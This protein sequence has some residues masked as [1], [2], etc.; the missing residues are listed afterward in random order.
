MSTTDDHLD[1]DARRLQELGYTQEL[2][3]GMSGFS[4]F[5]V[6]FSIISI[7]AGCITTYYLAMDAGGPIVISIGWPLVGLFVL[8]V[9]LAMAE[10]CSSY[11]TAGGLYYWAGQL[12]RRN[13]RVWAWYVG[14]F[15]FLG[16]VAV[17]A[18]IDYGAA[19]TWMALLNLTFGVDVTLT[20]TFIAFLVIITLHGLLNTF[21][22]NLVKL[23]S[24][25]SAWWHL[26]G[27]AVIVGILWLVPDQHQ[28]LAWT[29]TEFRNS[30]GWESTIYVFMIGL[31]MA[32]YTF[33]GYDASAHVAEETK[34]ASTEAP[35]GIVRSVWVSL[36]AGWVLL[37]SVTAAIQDYDAQ[38][39]SETGLP[40]AQI[41]IDAAGDDLGKL[42][43]LIAA[44]AQFFCGM[45]SVTA[46]SRMTYAFSRD[47][48]LPGSRIWKKV[49]PR[50]G[51][52]TNSI[53]FCVFWSV[54]L[55][56][57]AI[58]NLTAY[59][60]VTSVAVIGLYIAYVIPV[61]LRR[62]K[63]DYEVGPW[64]LGG[65]SPVIGW[66]AVAWV[67][68]IVVLFMLP[69]YAPG[70]FGDATFNY[71]PVAVLT[72]VVFSTVMWFV[73]GRKNFMH[74]AKDEYTTKDL[75]DI[76][77]EEEGHERARQQIL[78]EEE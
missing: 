71:A 52:P 33:T 56:L 9:A 27:V 36:L 47:N 1:E 75:D 69:A 70:S 13:K 64:N 24:D 30:T 51:T 31:L 32:Q 57:P 46:N 11:P 34:D 20:S 21:G 72:V 60:A 2:H 62:L 74:G 28:S 26:A 54:V 17:T 25:V 63:P 49:N 78:A 58:W 68:F 19:V 77:N 45:A 40:P 8:C 16:E 35:K 65:M 76:F 10:V 48:A 50:T 66:I 44:V 12:A 41:F 43:L 42:M 37:V 7:L 4:N 39:A 61:L 73:T 15:N 18:A 3:R 6:S 29:F 59:F 5:A 14:W 53:W 38:R 67:T 55:T 23:L 22:V